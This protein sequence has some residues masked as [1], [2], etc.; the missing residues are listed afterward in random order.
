MSTRRR[1]QLQIDVDDDLLP[2]SGRRSCADWECIEK[3]ALFTLKLFQPN[4]FGGNV[5]LEESF[6]VFETGCQ[7]VLSHNS[8]KARA[9]TVPSKKDLSHIHGLRKYHFLNDVKVCRK[10]PCVSLL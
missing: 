6:W 1:R 4:S 10:W 3:F 9:N 7:L 2:S 5:L 8:K